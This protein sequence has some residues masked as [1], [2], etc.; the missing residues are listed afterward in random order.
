MT[1]LKINEP[2][3]SE[4]L[5]Q[6]TLS[7]FLAW[8][9]DQ[10][11]RYELASGEVF[12][13]SRESVAH[14]RLKLSVTLAI[15]GAIRKAGLPCEAI[16]DGPGVTIADQSYFVPDVIVTCGEPISGDASL[17]DAPMIVVEVV[18]PS[19]RVFDVEHKAIYYFQ[20]QSIQHYLI[21]AGKSRFVVHH[22][23]TGPTKAEIE[24]VREG[25]I[26]LDPPGFAV[27]LE[28]IFPPA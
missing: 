23:R 25:I 10:P 19:T 13:M 16:I 12:A 6:M 18:S 1:V 7:E 14:A 5:P 27:A 9:R 3:K 21:V 20:K 24:L 26:T 22:R 15:S 2:E 11:G 17:I 8:N 4:P 28:D